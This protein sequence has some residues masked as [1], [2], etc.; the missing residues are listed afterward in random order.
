MNG[1]AR[2]TDRIIESAEE[3]EKS[4]LSD[5]EK[6]VEEIKLEAKAEASLYKA[7]ETERAEKESLNIIDRAQSSAD[8]E[9]RNAVLSAK[10]KCIE[11]AYEKARELI[12]GMK[13]DE[14]EKFLTGLC[15]KTVNED[16]KR[17]CELRNMYPDDEKEVCD[18]YELIFNEKDK[19][20][21]SKNV[22][23]ALSSLVD[24]KVK[25]LVSESCRDICA[26]VIIKCASVE[27]NNSVDA[28]LSNVRETS[29]SEVISIIFNS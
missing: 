19:K 15:A 16:Y 27:I 23:T 2:I 11:L 21:Y 12:L 25:L 10:A 20:E 5:A 14:Y 17:N 7:K 1:L 28:I 3:F 26:G 18:T 13:K 6:K 8:L 29:E 4:V 22:L 9:K 24:G